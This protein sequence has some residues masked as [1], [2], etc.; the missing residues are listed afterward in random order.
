MCFFLDSLPD[1]AVVNRHRRVDPFSR[2]YKLHTVEQEDELGLR[3]DQMFGPEFGGAF[4]A[5][6][7]RLRRLNLTEEEV[8]LLSGMVLFNPGM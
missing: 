8:A 2:A 7:L 4:V 3:V 5:S 6:S 1:L